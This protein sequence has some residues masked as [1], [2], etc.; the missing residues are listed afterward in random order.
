MGEGLTRNFKENSD[1]SSSSEEEIE[2][3]YTPKDILLDNFMKILLNDDPR[4]KCIFDKSKGLTYLTQSEEQ[5]SQETSEDSDSDKNSQIINIV[6]DL[7]KLSTYNNKFPPENKST[8]SEKES[9]I[10]DVFETKKP[11]QLSSDSDISTGED[12]EIYNPDR[13][14]RQQTL[15]KHHIYPE[16]KRYNSNMLQKYKIFKVEP[17][18][19]EENRTKINKN[20]KTYLDSNLIYTLM[21]PA[22]RTD[23]QRVR[24][25]D[26]QRCKKGA[27]MLCHWLE[28][29]IGG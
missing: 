17:P 1:E 5:L 14:K 12:A 19:H 22:D 18:I 21:N 7:S 10:S 9:V 3:D 8:L 2:L 4:K 29:F 24:S 23:R 25:E 28:R 11:G 15:K 26:L 6:P 27:I 13:A 16:L 20:Q